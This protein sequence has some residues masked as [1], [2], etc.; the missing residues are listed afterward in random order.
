MTMC[1]LLGA[2]P[3]VACRVSCVFDDASGKQT[4][5]PIWQKSYQ[6]QGKRMGFSMFGKFPSPPGNQQGYVDLVDLLIFQNTET[7]ASPETSS[8]RARTSSNSG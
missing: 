8:K 6:D 4:V 5:R 2:E 7:R 1:R 3:K